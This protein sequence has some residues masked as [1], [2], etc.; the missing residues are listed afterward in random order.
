M[1]KNDIKNIKIIKNI[2]DGLYRKYN[3]KRFIPPDPLQFVYRYEKKVDMEIAGFLAAMF[4]YGAV[5]QIE[6]FLNALLGRMGK[7]PAGFIKNFSAKNKKLFKSLKYRFNTSDDII[8]LLGILKKVLVRYGSIEKL[9]LKGYSKTDENIIPAAEKFVRALDSKGLKFLLSDPAKGGTSKRLFLFLRWMVR[10]DEADAGLW[11]KIDKSKLIV[12][13]DVHIG[14]LS[15]IL[16]LYN[17]KTVNLKTAIEITAG[18][19]EICPRDPVKYDFA[20]CR[21]GILENCSGKRNKYCPECEL[22]EL[23]RKKLYF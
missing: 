9:F 10:K 15:K 6:K 18:F 2:L 8:C 4:A 3:H 14:R 7:S 16:G 20:L 11:K 17:K 22:A 21:I 5:E 1:P 19:A 13:V 12:P 23:C